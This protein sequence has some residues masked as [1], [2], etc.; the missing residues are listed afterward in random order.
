M[1][2]E[3]LRGRIA[4][5][6]ARIAGLIAERMA[7]SDEIGRLKAEAGLPVR[8]PEAEERAVAS[9]RRAAA[10]AGLDPDAAEAVCRILIGES[11]ERQMSFRRAESH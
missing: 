1:G 9:Y 8:V 5:I 2:I 4:G 10:E 6:D 7:A 11:V 3:E